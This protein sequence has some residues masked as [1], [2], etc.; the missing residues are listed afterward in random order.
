MGVKVDKSRKESFQLHYN[1]YPKFANIHL[2]FPAQATDQI[3]EQI[4]WGCHHKCI[5]LSKAAFY[6]LES[7]LIICNRRKLLFLLLGAE[8]YSD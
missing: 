5:E 7:Q 8:L 6:W 1:I 4:K 3:A 2:H